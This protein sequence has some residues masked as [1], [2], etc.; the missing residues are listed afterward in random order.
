MKRKAKR[1]STKPKKASSSNN[2]AKKNS[3]KKAIMCS[4]FKQ[5]GFALIGMGIAFF[6]LN[7]FFG[8]SS[9]RNGIVAFFTGLG[10]I[11]LL[12]YTKYGE[13]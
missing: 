4:S 9:L 3:K 1:T 2:A 10:V 12:L 11:D 5:L 13:G 7:M 6:I 8:E